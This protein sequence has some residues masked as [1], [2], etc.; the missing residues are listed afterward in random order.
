MYYQPINRKLLEQ[1]KHKQY[2]HLL[3]RLLQF[4]SNK[5]TT[6]KFKE[7]HQE[8]CEGSFMK[9]VSNGL[10][11][12]T[13]SHEVLLTTMDVI[14]YQQDHPVVYVLDEHDELF[15]KPEDLKSIQ[16]LVKMFSGGSR[17]LTVLTG[18]MQRRRRRKER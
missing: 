15:H 12:P 14:N 9:Y 10:K 16:S 1:Q 8:E 4:N 17:K 7:R 3:Q 5:I 6:M 11:E 18:A 2:Q 13:K